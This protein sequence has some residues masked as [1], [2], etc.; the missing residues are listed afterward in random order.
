MESE[1]R[2]K[3]IPE[4]ELQLSESVERASTQEVFGDTNG[5]FD[6][7]IDHLQNRDLI[8]YSDEKI[9]WTG[10]NSNV[11]FIGDILGDRAPE[12][13]KTYRA[14]NELKKQAEQ[15]GGTVSWLAGNHENMCTAVLGGFDVES[16]KSPE[17]DM[18]ER[19]TSYAGNL[20]WGSFL[21]A[22]EISALVTE[23]VSVRED[24]LDTNR[25]LLAK[26][27]NILQL[28]QNDPAVEPEVIVEYEQGITKIKETLSGFE[29]FLDGYDELDNPDEFYNTLL[30]EYGDLLPDDVLKLAGKKI[31]ENRNTIKQRVL[32]E[33]PELFDAICE[34]KILDVQDD[35]LYLH[36]NCN[37]AMSDIIM[38]YTKR[39]LAVQDA[40]TQIN[41]FYQKTLRWYMSP[42][43]RTP[44]ELDERQTAY[45]NT[46]R[47]TF[48]TTSR[49]SR[50]NY[51][52]DAKLSDA[53]RA[54]I[55]KSFKDQGINAIV[56]GHNDEN[57]EAL[58]EDGLPIISVDR[59]VYKNEGVNVEKPIAHATI[60]TQ[61]V[62][63]YH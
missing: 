23:V 21:D 47:D 2:E 39:G 9:T 20:E 63:A 53:E 19:L 32:D 54:A 49:A 52:E 50:V 45:F 41:E 17:V 25:A 36:P 55:T 33:Q 61:G 8:D 4:K 56:H 35:V 51:S 59:S 14:L 10:G 28:I 18:D 7:F 38:S 16:G 11:M 60:S 3:F 31:L 6:S 62:L 57:G 15:A 1:T 43:P 37:K 42:E 27:E 22:T 13:F 34:Q 40:V 5:S 29:A 30:V 46:I 48:L 24:I 26:K 12:G 44:P 58:G